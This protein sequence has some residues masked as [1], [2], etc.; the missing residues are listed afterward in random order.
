MDQGQK[1]NNAKMFC[2]C[3]LRY[4]HVFDFRRQF[5]HQQKFIN[6]KNY[7]IYSILVECGQNYRIRCKNFAGIILGKMLLK[8]IWLIFLLEIRHHYYC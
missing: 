8:S 5:W 1:L 4:F 2:R 7:Q 3:L 6:S